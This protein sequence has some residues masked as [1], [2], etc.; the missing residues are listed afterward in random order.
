MMRFS[1]R[2]QKSDYLL[3]MIEKGRCVSLKQIA[4]TFHISRRTAKRMIAEL[5]E[6]GHLIAYCRSSRRFCIDKDRKES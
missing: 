3:E 1:E 5:R 6:Q 4:Y 2:K